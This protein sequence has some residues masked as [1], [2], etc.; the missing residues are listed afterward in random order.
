VC[1]CVSVPVLQSLLITLLI[2]LALLSLRSLLTLHPAVVP[3]WVAEVG[4]GAVIRGHHD[5]ACGAEQPRTL[6]EQRAGP[7]YN[8]PTRTLST[9]YC[10]HCKADPVPRQLPYTQTPSYK[11]ISNTQDFQ[12]LGSDRHPTEQWMLLGTFRAENTHQDQVF[13][14][15]V[16]LHTCIAT[17][18]FV[19]AHH[20]MLLNALALFTLLA[21]DSCNPRLASHHNTNYRI[22]S[23]CAI[24]S[25]VF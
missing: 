22:V 1:N 14:L 25:Y 19:R 16:H 15:K 24:S 20:T 18:L 21:T 12:L 7:Y 17:L 11:A 2:L 5:H 10:L 8:F 4:G 13:H 23:G 9:V 3:L 6:F